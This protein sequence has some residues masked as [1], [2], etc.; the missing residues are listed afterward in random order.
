MF[1]IEPEGIVPSAA[2]LLIGIA[3]A[4]FYF[5]VDDNLLL[6]PWDTSLSLIV[7]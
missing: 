3:E 7:Y 6:I 4:E 5:F 1:E 2:A